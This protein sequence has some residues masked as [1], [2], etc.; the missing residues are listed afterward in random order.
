MKDTESSVDALSATMISVSLLLHL[1]NVGRNLSRYFRPFQFRI[2]TAICIQCSLWY[3]RQEMLKVINYGEKERKFR[4]PCLPEGL[5]G[6]F[7]IILLEIAPGFD[8]LGILEIPVGIDTVAQ[9]DFPAGIVDLS[10]G[11]GMEQQE[12]TGDHIGR[13][14]D[15]FLVALTVVQG[16]VLPDFIRIV[17]GFIVLCT[18]GIGRAILQV[19][20]S[21]IGLI[22]FFNGGAKVNLYLVYLFL[23]CKPCFLRIRRHLSHRIDQ[24][25]VLFENSIKIGKP[26]SRGFREERPDIDRNAAEN[27]GAIGKGNSEVR[28]AAASHAL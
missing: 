10:D 25:T 21:A 11:I 2:M 4:K 18:A 12:I 1:I 8:H 5:I 7:P 22:P 16:I 15:E 19:N 24:G 13:I 3:I 28:E 14:K 17:A 6:Q 27:L 20:S 9:V 23:V 26:V